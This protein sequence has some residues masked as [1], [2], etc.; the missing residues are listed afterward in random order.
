M[1]AR[2]AKRRRSRSRMENRRL[3]I[4]LSY[5]PVSRTWNASRP[6]SW[7]TIMRGCCS[8]H[9]SL[10]SW[11]LRCVFRSL[12]EGLGR[13]FILLTFIDPTCF[14]MDYTYPLSGL[15]DGSTRENN[16]LPT[17]L[18]WFLLYPAYP[19]HRVVVSVISFLAM[20]PA[21]LVYP[22]PHFFPPFSS[23]WSNIKFA[24]WMHRRQYVDNVEPDDM[25]TWVVGEGPEVSDALG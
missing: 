17:C 20:F 18:F 11:L 9:E 15:P 2:V 10:A 4:F 1:E 7:V 8:R 21:V 3:E 5:S 24:D 16:D 13:L 14:Q 12:P 19:W 25:K 23:Q 22:F 6:A